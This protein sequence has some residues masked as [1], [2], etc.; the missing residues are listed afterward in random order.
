MFRMMRAV[1]LAG[2]LFAVTGCNKEVSEIPASKDNPTPEVSE[3]DKAKIRQAD[4]ER[5]KKV[6]ENRQSIKD[7]AAKKTKKKGGSNDK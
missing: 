4:E 5:A 3:E 6:L 1:V 7:K 2:A